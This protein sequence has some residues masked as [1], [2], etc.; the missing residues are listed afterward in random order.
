MASASR[1]SLFGLDWLNFFVASVQTGFGPF[2]AVYLTTKAWTQA[3]IGEALS[4]GTIAAMVSQLPAGALVDR[5]RDKRLAA[6]GAC[7]G[8]AVAAILFAAAPDKPAVLL[9]EV[10]HSFAS[11]ML[12]PAI[13]A[14]SLALVGHAGLGQRLGRN[15]RFAS[16]GNG[17]A[18]AVMGAC[19]SYFSSRA[20]FW[21]TAALMAPG[22]VAL[23]RIRR[24]E[25]TA[26]HHDPSD[27]T[28]PDVAAQPLWNDILGLLGNRRIL[29]FSVCAA[30]FHLSNAALLPLAAGNLTRDAGKLANLLI[31]ACIM[32]PQGILAVIAPW[33][34]RAADRSGVRRILMLGFAAVPLRAV[35]LAAVA[36]SPVLVVVVQLLDGL[37]AAVFGVMLPLMAAKLAEGTERFNLCMG[38]LGLTS[39]GGATISTLLAGVI[40]DDY[41]EPLAFLVLAACGVAAVLSVLVATPR[42]SA[43]PPGR[44]QSSPSPLEQVPANAAP[45]RS[46]DPG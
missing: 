1:R 40:A 34:G 2:I 4:L 10:V 17:I 46:T 29:A 36:S 6:A 9:A 14:I 5:L 37:S 11:G 41:S 31:A 33:V 13:A 39:A 45:P 22:V 24:R 18:A 38:L 35:L 19:G 7:I 25:M 23:S 32:L 42:G 16:L 28:E 26:L 3:E 44:G 20:V 15:A 21:L 8:V 30:L 12:G 27:E 43:P